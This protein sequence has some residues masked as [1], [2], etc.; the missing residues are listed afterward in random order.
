[1]DNRMEARSSA[2]RG[3]KRFDG[4]TALAWVVGGLVYLFLI[5]P[6]FVIIL[7]AFSPNAYPEFPPS[8]FSLRWFREVADN[9][10]W[11]KSIWF[12]LG[13]MVIVTLLTVVLGTTAAYGV[14]RLEFRGKQALL[15]FMLSPLMIPQVVMGIAL[16]YVF[17][18]MGIIGSVTGLVIGHMIVS[19]PYVIRTVGVSL[20]N[21]DPKLERASMSLGAG[22]VK[23]FFRVTLPLIKPGIVAGGVFSAVTSFG[24]VS[25]SLFVVSPSNMTVPVRI[26]NYI[27]QTFD[28]S[29]NAISVIFIA[30]AVIAL[31]VIERTIGLTKV[32]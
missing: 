16:L 32:M 14:S 3:T 17:T 11:M 28:P 12:S 24:E 18:S 21:L 5:L 29:V 15:S 30:V 20:S 19:F 26:F 2:R 10:A 7:S 13:L 6:V 31:V 23:T 1:M 4:W 25:I 27:D 8:E 22:P 9:A